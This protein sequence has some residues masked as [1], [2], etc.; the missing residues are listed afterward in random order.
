MSDA[1]LFERFV[2][3]Y[4]DYDMKVI[5]NALQLTSYPPNV[6]EDLIMVLSCHGCKQNPTPDNLKQLMVEAATFT[7]LTVPAAALNQLRKGIP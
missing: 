6:V 4:C 5:Q 1:L 3:S 2:T 7:F